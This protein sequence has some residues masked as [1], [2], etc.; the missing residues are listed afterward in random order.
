MGERQRAE[1]GEVEEAGEAEKRKAHA[2][3]NSKR[4]LL[5]PHSS[6]PYPVSRLHRSIY[7]LRKMPC[8]IRSSEDAAILFFGLVPS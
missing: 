8:C 1:G 7:S 6:P 2:A 3:F 4:L 5:T